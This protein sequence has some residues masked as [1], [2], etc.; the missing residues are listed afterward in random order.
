MTIFAQFTPVAPI[1]PATI[2]RYAPLVPPDVVQAWREHGAGYVGDGYFRFV[3]PARAELMLAGTGIPEG[4]VALFT[5]ALGDVVAWSKGLVLVFKYRWGVM[6]V[7]RDLGFA[8][9]AALVTDPGARDT[10]WEWQPY[11]EKT[12]RDG[13]PEFEQCYG[14]VPLLALGGAPNAEQ[15]KPA[16][17]YEHIALIV[18]FAGP[19]QLRGFLRLPEGDAAPTPPAVPVDPASL[20]AAQQDLAK[21]GEQLFRQLANAAGQQLPEVVMVIPVDDGVAVVRAVRGGGMILVASDRSV[22]Y[23]ASAVTFDQA[24]REFRSGSRTPLEK[25]GPAS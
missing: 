21:F 11:P 6:D 22:L 23:Q 7:G 10:T 19:P 8:R 12:A 4:S 9:L 1:E 13:V 3:D 14:F 18:Q 17:L 5:T 20:P 2:E 25:F 24:V 16:G 15:L